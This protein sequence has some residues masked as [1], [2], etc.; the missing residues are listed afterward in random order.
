MQQSAALP[1]VVAPLARAEIFIHAD[2]SR[3]PLACG[4]IGDDERHVA[5]LRDHGIVAVG[6]AL[7]VM[8]GMDVNVGHDG[9]FQLP[10]LFPYQAELAAIEFDDAV[11]E[12]MRN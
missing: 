5:H 7:T 3:Q 10:A 12:A 8:T 11:V 1:A 6:W 4:V 2:L 9:H